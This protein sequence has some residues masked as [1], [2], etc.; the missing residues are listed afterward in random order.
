MKKNSMKKLILLLLFCGLCAAGGHAQ[1]AMDNIA[2]EQVSPA[3]GANSTFTEEDLLDQYAD[4][5]GISNLQQR[6]ADASQVAHIQMRGNSNRGDIFQSGTGNIGAI[7][8]LGRFNE[9]T[10]NQTGND[11]LSLIHIE[12]RDNRLEVN[13]T[14]NNL[15]NL[16]QVLGAGID[17]DITQNPAEFRYQQ[18]GAANPITIASTAQ[19]V[20]II[21]RNN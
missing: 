17:M 19:N 4:L 10:L 3:D 9:S 8:I 15:G 11:L 12:G 7:T 1:T 20:P 16:V 5:T 14:G 21:I 13:Q 18:A 6:A 2:I